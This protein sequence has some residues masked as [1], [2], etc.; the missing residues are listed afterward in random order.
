MD[1]ARDGA[2]FPLSVAQER[3]WRAD[4]AIEGRLAYHFGL[5]VTL[6]GPLDTG[7]LEAA[8]GDVVSRH[9]I[10]RAG[11]T[12][13]AGRPMLS[14]A[15]APIPAVALPV[16]DS[17]GANPQAVA[18]AAIARPLVLFPGP[19][20]GPLWRAELHRFGPG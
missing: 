7:A 13:V 14:V 1:T 20:A 8:L 12:E 16:T 3:L 10:L 5:V 18:Q 6:D 9:E 4:Q 11:L 19:S 2:V 15:P 17:V